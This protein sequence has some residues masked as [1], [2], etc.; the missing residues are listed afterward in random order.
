MVS[1]KFTSLFH[2]LHY[3]D[4]L[5]MIG[6]PILGRFG[7]TDTEEANKLCIY[8]ILSDAFIVMSMKT[9]NNL[10]LF[11]KQCYLINGSSN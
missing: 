1:L 8:F 9:I 3:V 5:L 6:N 7:A 11:N 4:S 2:Q 10:F